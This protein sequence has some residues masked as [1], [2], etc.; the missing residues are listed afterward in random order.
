LGRFP[1]DGKTYEPAFFLT[2]EKPL[3]GEEPRKALGRILPK[4]PQ[5]ARAA[6]NLVWQKLMVVG[7][8]EPYDG[9]D[10]LRLDP[11]NPPPAGWTIQPANP[12][13]LEALAE[14][15][16][17]HNHSIQRVIKLIMKSNAYQLSASFP[18][19]WKDAYIPYYARR[20]AR[21]LNAPEAADIIATATDTPY[22]LQQFGQKLTEVKQLSD[23]FNLSGRGAGAQASEQGALYTLMQ[24]YFIQERNLPPMDKNTAT[25]MQAMV[26]MSSPL[27]NKR[28][29]GEGT[30]RVANLLKS[31]K[32]ENEV[33]EDLFLSSLVRRPTAEEMEVA[34]RLMAEDK[35]EGTET[36]QWALLNTAEFLLNH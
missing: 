28:V 5:F 26:L 17:T 1:R 18:G 20:F 31:G 35:K 34:K 30:T 21:V 23:P 8:V 14:D 12:E 16:R 7:L 24:A 29:S 6:V 33:I 19:K 9:F 36:I 11:K 2:G 4:H 3:P 13:L 25:P 32:S 10:L 22:A 15:F 27:V